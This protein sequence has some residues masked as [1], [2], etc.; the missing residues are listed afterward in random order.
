MLKEPR[1][2]AVK[3]RLAREIGAV[4]A[5]RFYRSVTANLIRRLAFDPRWETVLA[6]APDVALRKGCW[7]AG[8]RRVRQ[9]GGDLGARMERL[10]LAAGADRSVL[11]GSDLPSVRAAHIAD[12]FEVLADRDAV[13]G[14]AADGGFW[15]AGLKPVPRIGGV[16]DHV[17]WSGPHAL[18]DT[19]R[20]IAPRQAGFAATLSDV[21]NRRDYEMAA[22]EG[23]CVTLSPRPGGTGQA[24][25]RL[26]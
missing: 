26:R 23:L 13:F 21:D 9:G 1:M 5:L 17:R 7:P 14:P 20:N 4:A 18:A 3:T 16:F 11:I 24:F 15:L 22:G 19:L 25:S 10:L 8:I 6:V 2:G 12:A